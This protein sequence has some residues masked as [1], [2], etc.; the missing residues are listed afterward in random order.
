MRLPAPLLTV[1]G[2]AVSLSQLLQLLAGSPVIDDA[3]LED[4]RMHAT[5]G[6]RLQPEDAL[7]HWLWSALRPFGV[8]I[9]AKL[10]YLA[11][12]GPCPPALG[13]LRHRGGPFQLQ[14]LAGPGTLPTACTHFCVADSSSWSMQA[15]Q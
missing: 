12:G 2:E 3:I 1:V 10:L 11:T 6:A 9:R 13:F 8:G 5:Y 7:S 4:G 14:R 15:A